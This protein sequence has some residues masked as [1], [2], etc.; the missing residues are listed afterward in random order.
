MYFGTLRLCDTSGDCEH[1]VGV[2]S[3][4]GFIL[5]VHICVGQYGSYLIGVTP[6]IAQTPFRDELQGVNCAWIDQMTARANSTA[7]LQLMFEPPGPPAGDETGPEY[8][9]VDI[10]A[11][12]RTRTTTPTCLLNRPPPPV[13]VVGTVQL[14]GDGCP[15]AERCAGARGDPGWL[16]VAQI[17]RRVRPSGPFV[18]P[19]SCDS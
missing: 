18:S 5:H 14:H 6:K 15:Q 9:V 11:I 4:V 16:F 7:G 12:H 10:S 2:R 8:V 13:H 17:L 3:A 1:H 19:V